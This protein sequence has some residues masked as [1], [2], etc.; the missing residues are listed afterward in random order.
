MG[1]LLQNFGG[2]IKTFGIQ[3]FNN[4]LNVQYPFFFAE[5]MAY[6]WKE[7][8]RKKKRDDLKREGIRAPRKLCH[9]W[10]KACI[11]CPNVCLLT[12]LLKIS[13]LDFSKFFYMWLRIF[14][15]EKLMQFSFRVRFTFLHKEPKLGFLGFFK[16][17]Y[18]LLFR[19]NFE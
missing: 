7:R 6:I 15:L 16:K 5:R 12:I 3:L 9:I 11:V 1:S 8:D 14:N 19:T 4:E 13:T 18:N 2:F 17:L 10:H